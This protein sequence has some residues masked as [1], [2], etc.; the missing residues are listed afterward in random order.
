[1][2][3]YTEEKKQKILEKFNQ[4]IKE[5]MTR[6]EAGKIVGV[7]DRSIYL[8]NKKSNSNIPQIITHDVESEPKKKWSRRP[9]NTE[10][11]FAVMVPA[12]KLSEV[13]NVLSN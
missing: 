4:L 1:M 2:K 11:Q 7:S 10:I 9:K 8:W 13:L 6:G 3:Y 5:G 12:N